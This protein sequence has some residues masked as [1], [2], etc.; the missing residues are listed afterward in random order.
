M[1]KPS[2]IA[3]LSAHL[4]AEIL[5]RGRRAGGRVQPGRWRRPRRRRATWPGHPDVDMVSF[6]GSTRAG[7]DVS[8]RRRPRSS[9]SRWNW[10]A[11]PP[12]IILDD[13]DFETA[14]A[15]RHAHLHGQ[16]RASP[17]TH[18]TRMLVP[19]DRMDEAIA[20]RQR[21]PPRVVKTGDPTADDTEHRPDRVSAPVRQG[22]LADPEGHRR[23]RG[24]W[25]AGGAERPD[26]CDAGYFVQPTVFARR[27]PTT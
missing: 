6:T 3:P 24:R 13:A 16:R 27:R 26:G 7:V 11:S 8:R 10:A 20:H 25:P 1:L 12:N 9:G 22:G 23:G 18:P 2:E 5:R 17:A 15:Q 21:R 14:V 19:N 4:F